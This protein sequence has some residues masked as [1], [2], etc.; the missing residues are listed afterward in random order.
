MGQRLLP[1]TAWYMVVGSMGVVYLSLGL[2][3]PID[4]NT[5]YLPSNEDLD[6][7]PQY[8]PRPCPRGTDLA[9][10]EVTW[11]CSCQGLSEVHGIKDPDR[12][13]LQRAPEIAQ[14]WWL[15][16]RC[17]TQPAEVVAAKSTELTVRVDTAFDICKL[18]EGPAK[19]WPPPTLLLEGECHMLSYGNYLSTHWMSRLTAA[20]IGVR[21]R[22]T[23]C[24]LGND[25]KNSASPFLRARGPLMVPALPPTVNATSICKGTCA[26]NWAYPHECKALDGTTPARIGIVTIAG[27]TR[28]R[29]E[30]VEY[31]NTSTAILNDL[32]HTLEATYP[33][34]VVRVHNG[35]AEHPTAA[36]SRLVL[37]TEHTVCTGISTFCLWAVMASSGVGHVPYTPR[38]YPWIANVNAPNVVATE[39]PILSGT[40]AKGWDARRI[41]EWLHQPAPK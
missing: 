23:Q 22:L 31:A 9:A 24:R 27:Q 25:P 4:D 11:G 2:R 1:D 40:A 26:K 28:M 10:P 15:K 3:E 29:Y 34:A 19:L 32:V 18:L 6:L 12:L 16:H 17:K 13:S 20:A 35:K 37:A 33:Q 39:P 30:D 36:I 41:I 21:V 38:M 14:T 8:L 7:R 5:T